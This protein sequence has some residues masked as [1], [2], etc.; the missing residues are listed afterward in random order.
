MMAENPLA[1]FLTE[2]ELC[3]ATG[4]ESLFLEADSPMALHQPSSD[5]FRSRQGQL[6]RVTPAVAVP[7]ILRFSEVLRKTEIATKASGATWLEG[8]PVDIGKWADARLS[9]WERIVLDRQ[10]R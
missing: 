2:H 4:I 5:L 9:D 7:M 6:E 3:V 10:G 1:D 8:F